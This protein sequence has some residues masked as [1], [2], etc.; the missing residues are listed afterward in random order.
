MPKI[1]T[2]LDD[3][4]PDPRVIDERGATKHRLKH[5]NGDVETGDTG[6][7]TMRDCPLERALRK[8]LIDKQAYNAGAK[9]RH[10]WYHSGIAPMIGSLD[11]N[12][13]FARDV[14]AFGPM[15]KT[16]AQLFHRQRYREACKTVGL[17]IELVLSDAICREIPLEDI[18]YKLGFNNEPQ[19]RAAATALFQC[20]LDQLASLWGIDS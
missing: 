20:G 17:R 13:V 12:R 7:V 11:L 8:E 19:S 15:P 10:H 4:R 16:E 6:A 3:F 2:A 9:F 5:A 18:G 1:K 14:F